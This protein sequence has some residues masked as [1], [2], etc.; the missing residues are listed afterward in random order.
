MSS[1]KRLVVLENAVETHGGHAVA[2][3]S[4]IFCCPMNC[5]WPASSVYG[6]FLARRPQWVAISSS[7]ERHIEESLN[8][9]LRG[10][11]RCSRWNAI[12]LSKMNDRV[13]V[14]WNEV[15]FFVVCIFSKFYILLES[16]SCI[17]ALICFTSEI[18]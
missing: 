16:I 7:R 10:Q 17:L 14:A 5:S 6:I 12:T 8:L 9:T 4:L 3:S 18:Q 15:Q 1:E 2:Q 11:R 13:E